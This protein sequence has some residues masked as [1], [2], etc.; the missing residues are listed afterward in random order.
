MKMKM[1]MENRSHR[2]DINSLK[3]RHGH[4]YSTYKVSLYEYAYMY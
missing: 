2:Y 1:E 4:E 3:F